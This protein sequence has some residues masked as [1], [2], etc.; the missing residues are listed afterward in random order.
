MAVEARRFQVNDLEFV[1]SVEKNGGSRLVEVRF[2][3]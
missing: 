1:F 3:P 2:R